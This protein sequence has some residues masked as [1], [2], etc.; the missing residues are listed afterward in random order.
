MIITIQKGTAHGTVAASP[1]KSECHRL[2]IGAALAGGR[3]IVRGF[4]PSDDVLATVDGITALGAS[5]TWGG[6]M[7][8]VDGVGGKIEPK[9]SVLSCRESGSTLR[10]LLPLCLL[11]GRPVTLSGTS[12]LFRR[13]LDLYGEICAA[14]GLTYQK[15]ENTV[16]VCGPLRP[17]GFRIPC[18]ISSQFVTGLLLALPLLDGGSR[19]D[20][21]P[22]Y[23]SMPY[24][25]VTLAVLRTFGIA[26]RYENRVITVPGHQ[27]YR[28][29]D[30]TVTGD[31]T[32]SA[33][34]AALGLVGGNVSVA[35]LDPNSPQ[36]D[37]VWRDFFPLFP[38]CTPKIDVSDTPDLAPVYLALGALK[39]GVILTGTRR[40]ADKE[41]D[42][43]RA[44][45]AELGKCG[46]TVR[47]EENAVTVEPDGFH[48]PTEP[49]DAHG[50]H[51][52]AMA[53]S[54]VL[55]VTGGSLRGAESVHKSFPDYW[56]KLRS[57]GVF[58]TE[59]KE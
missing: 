49:L 6:G 32:S 40:L 29:S 16:I 24:I 11:A 12:S 38:V 52:I 51:R 58:L 44:M 47:V 22:P 55:T 10:F 41:S 33:V 8:V 46:V 14:Q 56:E 43:G 53:L 17:G 30:V 15:T 54:L 21:L 45:A 28:P 23:E 25:D 9:T 36:G 57:L 42:R 4:S 7:A 35:G 18:G 5:V 19:I 37:K 26:T 2:L 20:L 27:Q 34:F 50:D 31:W 59:E 48:P 13:P 1:S 39:H 3:S